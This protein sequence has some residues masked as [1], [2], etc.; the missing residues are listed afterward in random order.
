MALQQGHKKR[1]QLNKSR[2]P[3][4]E[5][6]QKKIINPIES[7]GMKASLSLGPVNEHRLDVLHFSVNRILKWRLLNC[8]LVFTESQRFLSTLKKEQMLPG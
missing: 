4:K 7:R 6:H 8:K 2:K 5:I 3:T 1:T